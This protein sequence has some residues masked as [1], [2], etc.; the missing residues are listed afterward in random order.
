MPDTGGPRE[1][2]AELAAFAR[3]ILD[4]G[5][6][7]PPV[8]QLPAIRGYL[9]EIQAAIQLLPEISAVDDQLEV[10]FDPTWPEPGS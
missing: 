7:Q 3:S 1:P 9:A 8:E 4:L 5:G 10:S 6:F 2:Y